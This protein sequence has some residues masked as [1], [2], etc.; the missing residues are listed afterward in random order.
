MESGLKSMITVDPR[1]LI[2]L[3]EGVKQIIESNCD[4]FLHYSAKQFDVEN[5][6]SDTTKICFPRSKQSVPR[7][8]SD[9]KRV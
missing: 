9:I 7:R 1:N 5:L 6:G 8:W 2:E 3:R 4:Q